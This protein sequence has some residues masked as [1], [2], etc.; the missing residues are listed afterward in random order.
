MSGGVVSVLVLCCAVQGAVSCGVAPTEVEPREPG[1]A[2]P[3][4]VEPPAA[5][6]PTSPSTAPAP[7]ALPPGFSAGVPARFPA[8]FPPAVGHRLSGAPDTDVFGRFLRSTVV[9]CGPDEQPYFQRYR[10]YLTGPLS[11]RWLRP[12]LAEPL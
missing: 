9:F 7:C 1:G 3:T 12:P 6:A 5:D 8:T 2:A 11:G 4:E 10:Y